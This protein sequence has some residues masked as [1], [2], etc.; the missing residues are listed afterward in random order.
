MYQTNTLYT[1][2][3]Y[4]LTQQLYLNKKLLAKKK[5]KLGSKVEAITTVFFLKIIIYLFGCTGS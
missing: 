3:I 2:S 4:N 5:K 1:L